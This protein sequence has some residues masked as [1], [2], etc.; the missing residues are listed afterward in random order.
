MPFE[1]LREIAQARLPV[2]VTEEA[3]IDKLRVLRAAELVVV[4]LPRVDAQEQFA[5]V[6]SLTPQGRSL[7]ESSDPM[8]SAGEFLL[9]ARS[10]RAAHRSGRRL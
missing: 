6:L 9:G 1:Y 4:M 10:E 7:L 5:R 3:Q 2:T 8:A